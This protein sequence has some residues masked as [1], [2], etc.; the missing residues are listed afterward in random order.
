MKCPE[1]G[2]ENLR[3]IDKRIRNGLPQRRRECADCQHRFNTVEI[4]M[5]QYE[6]VVAVMTQKQWL[7][8]QTQRFAEAVQYIMDSIPDRNLMK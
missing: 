7:V 5:D 2:S 1:C 6:A 8:E 4:T 3:V